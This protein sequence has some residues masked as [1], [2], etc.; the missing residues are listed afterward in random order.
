MYVYLIC[1]C[2]VYVIHV[3]FYM[4]VHVCMCTYFLLCIIC[5]SFTHLRCASSPAFTEL[6]TELQDVVN[7]HDKNYPYRDFRSFAMKFLFPTAEDDHP[8]LKPVQVRIHLLLHVLVAL[9]KSMRGLCKSMRGQECAWVCK[10]MRE[11]ARVCGGYAI[12]CGGKS[13]R[14]YAGVCGGMQ[15]YAG[16][17]KG[18]RGYA[19]VCGGMQEYAGVCKSVCVCVGGVGVCT[20][21]VLMHTLSQHTTCTILPGVHYTIQMECTL[22]GNVIRPSCVGGTFCWHADIIVAGNMCS[23]NWPKGISL[24]V[25][26]GV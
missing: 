24:K 22:C 15:E 4:Y 23:C 10:S 7:V 1:V 21:C 19:R 13:V 26:Q 16:V 14:G 8:I 11:Y 18:V 5:V 9:C 17:C 25:C 12:V 20:F 3:Y 2:N 6:Q